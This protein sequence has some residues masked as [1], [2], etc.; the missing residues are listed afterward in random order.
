MRTETHES[1]T[2]TRLPGNTC[3][4]ISCI[5]YDHQ[6]D[7]RDSVSQS[8]LYGLVLGPSVGNTDTDTDVDTDKYRISTKQEHVLWNAVSVPL[9]L[10]VPL[11]KY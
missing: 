4:V 11:W 6:L 10:F 2:R 3:N 5:S 9:L 8:S 7:Y 1:I